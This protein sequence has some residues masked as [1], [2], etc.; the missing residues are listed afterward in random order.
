MPNKFSWDDMDD[1][2]SGAAQTGGGKFSWDAMP[3]HPDQPQPGTFDG[4]VKNTINS[5]PM[6]GGVVGGILGTPA[7]AVVG[8]L[9]NAVGAGIGGYLGTATKNLINKY[10]D[11][12]SAPKTMGQVIAQPVVGGVEQGLAQGSGEAVAP[13]VAKG[14]QAAGNAVKWTGTKALSNAFGVNPNVIKE[15]AQFSDRINNAPDVEALKNI[16]DDFVGKLSSDVESKKLSLDQAKQ[17]YDAH[18]SDLKDAYKSAGYDARDAVTSAQQTLKDAHN[19]RI[20][21]LSSDVYDTVNQLKSDVQ[22]G[23]SKALETLNK[24]NAKLDLSPVLSHIDDSI[25]RLNQAGT[26]EA[27][28]VADKLKAYKERLLINQENAVTGFQAGDKVNTIAPATYENTPESLKASG[29]ALPARW[30]NGS[31][32][33]QWIK[34]GLLG[35]QVSPPVEFQ[36]ISPKYG[37]LTKIDAPA[38]KKLIQGLDQI[39]EYSPM[40]GS[41]DKAKNAAF[42]GVRSS[43]DQTLK[44][45][46]PEY[47][48]AMEP[49]A[50]DASLLNRV[51][52]FGDKQSAAGILQRIGAP[53]Q[54][55]RAQALQELGKKYGTDFVGAANPVNLPEQQLLN[56]VQGTQ[57]ALRP[58]RVAEKIDQTVNSSRQKSALDTAQSAYDQSQSGLAPFKSIAPNASGQTTAQQKLMQLGKG[59]NIE[60]N[61]MFDRLGK[62][63]DT[64]FAQAMKDNSVKAAFQKGAT[65]G[66]R[67]TVRGALLGFAVGGPAGAAAGGTAGG[68]VD[69]WGPVLTKRILDGVIKV[70]KSPTVEAIQSL[71]IP[72]SIKKNMIAGLENYMA[73]APQA[74]EQYGLKNVADN[75]SRE[76]RSPAK[77]YADGGPVINPD[78]AKALQ[79]GFFGALGGGGKQ[80]PPQKPDPNQ[81]TS[82]YAYGGGPV[83]GKA[84]V[85]GNSSKNDVV[86]AMLSPGEIVLP[87]SVTQAKNAPE[88]A[89]KFVADHL[90]KAKGPDAWA[91]AGA[92]KLGISD[93]NTLSQLMQHP[94]GKDLLVQASSFAPGSKA[95]QNIQNQI[96]KG[97]G[98]RK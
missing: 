72:D 58:D 24:S 14:I 38:A 95:L 69:Q 20:Q 90:K 76:N 81:N 22:N 65:N 35:K 80:P 84:K 32:E 40:A 41:F 46:V 75:Q 10:Y 59:N 30:I 26:D 77:G 85:S 78:K 6:I 34:N 62:L 93:P 12:E 71:Q 5:L 44:Q 23:S 60:L 96:Q 98:K 87:R 47:A 13:Y 94:K 53:N 79:G 74:A 45:S 83:P 73:H 66:S 27:L 8:P 17:A 70:S 4:T 25:A 55:E 3:D 16:S 56:R 29:K 39:T 19:S 18:V 15:Y 89:A 61:D 11:P 51:Q 63:T 37:S 49:V 28:S 2:H 64:D 52:D 86:H 21:Q 57:D 97:F 43:L 50:A 82:N 92:K 33:D 31:D 67:N 7:D 68:I 54:M 1:A 48:Q 91:H 42:K 36:P 9:G 88:A